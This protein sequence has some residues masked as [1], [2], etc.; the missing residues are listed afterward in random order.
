MFAADPEG[1]EIEIW[2]EIPTP[3]DPLA[4]PDEDRQQ[5]EPALT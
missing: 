1:Y 5:E 4:E 2:F 3:V